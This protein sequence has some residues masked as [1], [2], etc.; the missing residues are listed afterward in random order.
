VLIKTNKKN[1]TVEPLFRI[2][3]LCSAGCMAH[4]TQPDVCLVSCA[5]V[6]LTAFVP[7]LGS[8]QE[9]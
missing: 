4:P 8:R 5:L 1:I 6:V 3:S 2:V 7:S 9:L